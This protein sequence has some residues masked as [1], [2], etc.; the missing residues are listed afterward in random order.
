MSKAKQVGKK[1]FACDFHIHTPSSKCFRG[2]RT[3]WCIHLLEQCKENELD[4][5]AIT[6]HNSIQGYSEFLDEKRRLLAFR[7]QLEDEA[8]SYPEVKGLLD[9]VSR[10]AQLFETLLVL[11][12]IEYDAKPGV[13]L[14]MIFPPIVE[15]DEISDFLERSGYPREHQGKENPPIGDAWDILDAIDQASALGGICIAA[16]A[17]SGKGIYNVL[18]RG[19]YR[20]EIF[21]DER[22][23]AVSFNNPVTAEK[24]MNLLNQPEYRRDTPLAFIQC[25]D[26]HGGEDEAPG[27]PAVYLMLD[28]PSFSEVKNALRNPDE[29]VSLT[30]KL[31]TIELIKTLVCRPTTHVLR[32]VGCTESNQRMLQYICALSNNGPG[33]IIVGVTEDAH[34]TP[35]GI[36]LDP[37]SLMELVGELMDQISPRPT[38]KMRAYRYSSGYIHTIRVQKGYRPIHSIG[39]AQSCYII[40]ENR[41]VEASAANL[42]H[43]VEEQ[44][45]SDF[46]EVSGAIRRR[47]QQ[48]LSQLHALDDESEAID[49]LLRL[50]RV[51][52]PLSLLTSLRILPPTHRTMPDSVS[53]VRDGLQNGESSGNTVVLAEQLPR[54]SYSSLR[55]TVPKLWTDDQLQG[56]T[57]ES[58]EPYVFVCPGGASYIADEGLRQPYRIVVLCPNTP[59]LMLSLPPDFRD[60]I[61]SDVL[62]AY[63]KSSMCL[64]YVLTLHDVAQM[65][66]L[67]VAG[68][69]PIPV[70]ALQQCSPN[71]KRIMKRIIELEH[72]FLDSE[73]SINA[74][75]GEPP[76]AV[77]NEKLSD[78]VSRHNERVSHLAVEIDGLIF[79][80]LGV[81]EECQA[82]INRRISNSGLYVHSTENEDV[83]EV[84]SKA[85][86]M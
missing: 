54:L 76:E 6:D 1:L 70:A 80:A 79:D 67:S 23:V 60:S 75:S 11:P 73:T 32:D 41:P 64:W 9:D 25:S 31:E 29:A 44:W 35:I 4:I 36:S 3:N 71:I 48:I 65:S 58:S 56:H 66:N 72:E 38:L 49:T 62:L 43:I 83:A 5:I 39:E 74:T 17:D 26:F 63:L 16:H 22:L 77:A 61:T 81:R 42:V 34:K 55:Y 85:T 52:V 14:L 78:L 24:M 84:R 15:P 2:P 12:G 18:D 86:P 50:K 37:D 28:H 68:S 8:F 7:K 33:T 69:I 82:A 46:R 10:K 59:A 47:R 51:S 27:K 53:K 20:A 19:A 30:P 21:R 57:V 45:M 13:H 40:Q